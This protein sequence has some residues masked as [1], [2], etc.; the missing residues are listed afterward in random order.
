MLAF[1]DMDKDKLMPC[2]DRDME[3]TFTDRVKDMDVLCMDRHIVVV[4]T[5]LEP[6]KACP[7]RGRDTGMGFMDMEQGTLAVCTEM[8]F[9]AGDSETTRTAKAARLL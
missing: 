8:P 6:V 4:C 2:T 9:M 1:T 5:D 7:Y 3:T